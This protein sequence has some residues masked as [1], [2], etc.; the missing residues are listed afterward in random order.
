MNSGSNPPHTRYYT[1]R[2]EIK[3]PKETEKR[4]LTSIKRYFAEHMD[5]DIGDLKASLLL[6]FCL[7][8]IGPSIYNR[9]IADAQMHLQE[10]VTDLDGACFAPEFGYW[11]TNRKTD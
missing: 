6:D 2:M 3:L 9:A 1:D 5:D 11:K 4:L 8:E 10:K 7:R